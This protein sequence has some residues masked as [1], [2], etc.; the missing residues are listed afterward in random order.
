M[1][2]GN[3]HFL[4]PAHDWTHD[5]IRDGHLGLDPEVVYSL[6]YEYSLTREAVKVAWY[7]PCVRRSLSGA[8]AM[9][10]GGELIYVLGWVCGRIVS[11]CEMIKAWSWGRMVECFSGGEWV[12]AWGD[13]WV[14]DR[15]FWNGP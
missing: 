15:K 11:W 1:L 3:N 8:S 9:S 5:S 13:T 2:G 12:R 6:E 7:S 4:T 14:I 10:M